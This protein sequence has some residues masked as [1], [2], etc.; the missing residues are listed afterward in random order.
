MTLEKRLEASGTGR[1]RMVSWPRE[2]SVK[3]R[4]RRTDFA[5]TYNADLSLEKHLRSTD[6]SFK[7]TP[8]YRS[9][10][11]QLQNFFIDPLTGLESGHTPRPAAA[12][13]ATFRERA[14]A[15]MPARPVKSRTRITAR[16]QP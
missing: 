1:I 9:T 14:P 7:L 3:L 15:I 4:T 5:T 12:L 8:F 11:D 6:W 16:P 13:H 2:A 10:K